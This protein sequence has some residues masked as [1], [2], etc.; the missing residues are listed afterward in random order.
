MSSPEAATGDTGTLLA[1][2]CNKAM[3]GMPS[4]ILSELCRGGL[5]SARRHCDATSALLSNSVTVTATVY[6]KAWPSK[7]EALLVT[8]RRGSWCMCA[9]W[10][11][12]AV[13]CLALVT[14]LTCTMSEGSWCSFL[15]T[16]A[17]WLVICTAALS[18]WTSHKGVNS[19][20]TS[21]SCE[22][23]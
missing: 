12:E 2:F 15:T 16:P 8:M 18:L 13:Q 9:S 21:P 14:M 20:T 17:Y 4:A 10:C 22:Q 23:Q 5:C 3:A 19:S 1:E 7:S 11:A 6:S